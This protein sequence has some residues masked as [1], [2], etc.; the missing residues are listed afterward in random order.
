MRKL[1]ALALV[2]LT[3]TADAGVRRYRYEHTADR[4]PAIRIPQFIVVDLEA[5][6]PTIDVREGDTAYAIDSDKFLKRTASAWVEVGG[7]GSGSGG[8]T[9]DGSIVRLTTAGDDVHAGLATDP[10]AKLKASSDSLDQVPLRLQHQST[11]AAPTTSNLQLWLDAADI[12]GKVDGDPISQW[13][14]S[15][16]NGRHVTQGTGSDQPTYKT[17]I[18]NGQPV[19]RFDGSNDFLVSSALISSMIAA[20]AYTI[21]AV[22]TPTTISSNN[23][24]SYQNDAAYADTGG[25]FALTFKSTPTAH[26]FNWDGNED[27]TSVSITAATPVLLMTRHDSGN[28]Y[29]SK[30]GETEASVA[31]GNTSTLTGALRVGRN[32][33]SEFLQGDIAELLI[34]NVVLSASD[35]NAILYYLGYKYGLSVTTTT[36]PNTDYLIAQSPS[37]G[38]VAGVNSAAQVYGA[39]LRST[40]LG[41]GIATTDATGVLGTT[42]LVPVANGGTGSAP[43]SDDQVLVS[44]SAAAA[45]WKTVPDCDADNQVLHYD[46][47]TNA[48]S[49]GDDDSGGAGSANVVEVE[50]DF[51]A[52][53]DTTASTTVTGLTWV[54]TTSVIVCAP[55]LFAT[56]DRDDGDEDALVENLTVAVHSRVAST[57]FT[58]MAHPAQGVAYGKFKVHCTGS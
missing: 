22:V 48:F 44:D 37:G 41:A 8:W 56:A 21:F 45:T 15:S 34:Y 19:V 5:E 18:L 36:V 28:L 23:A 4:P 31:S 27:T 33:Q 2:F 50:V 52:S 16:G 26:V 24:L 47:A 58:V 11:P 13:D 57:G 40:T 46:Q 25:F 38:A 54:G 42:S 12:V 14:D 9:D 3:A 30:N 51:G 29:I 39:T 10:G 35:R 55:T 49:C 43:A 7:G 1:L 32:Y 20:S 17:N 6:L 53:G